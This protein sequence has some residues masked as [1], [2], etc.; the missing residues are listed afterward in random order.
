MFNFGAKDEKDALSLDDMASAIDSG[1]P[2][3]SI[4]G[5]PSLGD[6]VLIDLAQQRGIEL[7]KTDKTV[8]E[9][10]WKSGN[11]AAVLQG[12]A[13]NRRRRAEFQ[14][15]VWAGLAYPVKLLLLIPVAAFATYSMTGPSF[16]IGVASCYA[17]IA[18]AFIFISRK[19]ARGDESLERYPV[20]G[21]LLEDLRELP[22][23]ESL[24]ALYSAGMPIVQ[25]HAMAVR[26][27]HMHGLRKRLH[28]TQ[29][30]IEDGMELREA[31][32][33]NG[34]LSSETLQLLATGEQSGQLEDALLRSLTRRQEVAGRKL[35]KTAKRIGSIAYT[36]AVAGVI[37]IVY[38]FYSGYLSMLSSV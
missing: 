22:Y 2:I 4:G 30:M 7:S 33:K 32:R 35:S 17:L 16:A 9:S 37:I 21:S 6:Q 28:A 14:R 18:V 11:S 31:L 24:H 3:E 23:L 27:V 20:I 26:S 12:R 13:A 1:L 19:I 10:G 29:A 15:E 34:G 38:Q 5:N 25:A 8:L 36:L